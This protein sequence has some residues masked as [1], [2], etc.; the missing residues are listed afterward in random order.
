MKTMDDIDPKESPES[1]KLA[2]NVLC[3]KRETNGEN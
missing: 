3:L 2:V 1:F